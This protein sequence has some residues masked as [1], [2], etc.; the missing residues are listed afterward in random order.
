[1][2]QF[3]FWHD[4]AGVSVPHLE[5]AIAWYQKVLGFEV[6]RR[7]VI[8]AIPAK[9]AIM[10]NGNLRFEIFEPTGGKAPTEVRSVPDEDVRIGGNK[11]VCFGVDNV[12]AVGEELKR[13]Q[14]DIVWIKQFPNGSANIILRDNAGNLIE[15]V[16]RTRPVASHAS[17]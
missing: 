11:H 1:M 7:I 9:V 17:L 13:R 6:E 12:L 2:K 8:E 4:H 14:A 5:E 15:F 10:I 16:Q 3:E